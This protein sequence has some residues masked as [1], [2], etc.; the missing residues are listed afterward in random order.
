MAREKKRLFGCPACGFRVSGTEE[1]CSRCGARFGERARFECPFC[2]E[3][4]AP[5][6]VRCPSC[7]VR[8]KDFASKAEKRAS[9]KNIDG[10]LMDIIEK[11][12]KEVKEQGKKLSCPMCSWMVDGSEETCPKCGVVFSEAVA[13]QCPVCAALVSADTAE[14]GE[15]G[16][17]FLET[18]GAEASHVPPSI[19]HEGPSMEATNRD[20]APEPVSKTAPTQMDASVTELQPL[21]TIREEPPP[22][23]QPEPREEPAPADSEE[24]PKEEPKKTVLRPRTMRRKE[25]GKPAPSPGEEAPELPVKKVRRRKLKTK[26]KA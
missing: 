3:P 21:E 5:D 24:L 14:C 10:L 18:E 26:P 17:V 20:I 13:Y 4:V 22:E 8:F 16:S 6:D 25:I 23:P 12:A 15:C 1:T 19:P 2:G 11:E 9:D 7:M